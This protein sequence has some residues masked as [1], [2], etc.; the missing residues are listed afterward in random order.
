M[1]KND[2]RHRQQ[3][4][5]KYL[6]EVTNLYKTRQDVRVFIEIIMSLLAVSIFGAFAIRPTLVTIAELQT[7]I[8]TKNDVLV[9][10]NTKIRA[11]SEA[12]TYLS[13]NRQILSLFDTAV[14]NS[15]SV[16]S[17]IQ[18]IEALAE[19]NNITL[20]SFTL[21]DIELIKNTDVEPIDVEISEKNMPQNNISYSMTAT[22]NFSSIN[23]F[24]NSIE[25]HRR[26]F[27]ST[28]ISVE[29]DRNQEGNVIAVTLQGEIPYLDQK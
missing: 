1:A 6:F 8:G 16:S 14:P 12:E 27:S 11:L 25:N 17:Y 28:L 23:T 5:K 19:K 15:P 22:G 21:K 13:Q 18:Q 24:I 3:I 26:R 4:Y 9:R 10:L 2:W 7:E 20:T 29:K